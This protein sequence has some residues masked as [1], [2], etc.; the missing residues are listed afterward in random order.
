MLILAANGPVTC[1]FAAQTANLA[2]NGHVNCHFA[3]L[4]AILAANEG[5]GELFLFLRVI[6]DGV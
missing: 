2:A 5:S 6:Y 1:H 4:T 3:A